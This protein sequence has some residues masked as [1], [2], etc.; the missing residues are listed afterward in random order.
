[1]L[2]EVAVKNQIKQGQKVIVM[3]IGNSARPYRNSPLEDRLSEEKI[4]KVG[5][6]YF[7]LEG[8]DNTK[9][10]K[11]RMINV[12]EYSSNFAVYLN[13][14]EIIDEDELSTKIS[15][16]KKFFYDF[17]KPSSLSLSDV[18]RIHAVL[19]DEDELTP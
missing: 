13:K 16:I 4:S 15:E 3:K 9:F 12:S 19:F 8:Y 11:E 7:Y 2:Q 14:Q 10:C 6:K 18:R 5:N 1:V 17:S